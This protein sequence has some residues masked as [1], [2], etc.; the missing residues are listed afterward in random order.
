MNQN[1]SPYCPKMLKKYKCHLHID[2]CM[3]KIASICYLFQYML[4]GEDQLTVKIIQKQLIEQKLLDPNNEIDLY[5][6]GWYVSATE[7]F[8]RIYKFPII[9]VRPHSELLLIHLEHEKNVVFS[10]Y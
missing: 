5:V 4:K 1:V 2:I 3:T 10:S 8:W 7:A 9:E 6:N